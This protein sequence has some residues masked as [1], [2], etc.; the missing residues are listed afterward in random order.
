MDQ[1]RSS[2]AQ[3]ALTQNH[4][5][6]AWRRAT[7]GEHRWWFALALLAAVVLQA[8]LPDRFSIHPRYLAQAVELIALI[9]LVLSHPTR[10][11]QRDGRIRLLSQLLLGLIAVTNSISVVLLVHQ[12]TAGGR[13]PAV[14]LLIG[15]GEI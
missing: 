12:I 5:L 6:P 8:L 11:D 9:A 2:I 7:D 1:D 10:M 4:P 3:P 13:L 14:E 15:G